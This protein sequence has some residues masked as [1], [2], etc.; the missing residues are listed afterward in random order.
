MS[1]EERELIELRRLFDLAGDVGEVARR[2]GLTRQAVRMKL[3]AGVRRG[4]YGPIARQRYNPGAAD[5]TRSSSEALTGEPRPEQRLY[6]AY[7]ALGSLPAV[8]R[9]FGFSTGRVR[10]LLV[11]AAAEG[12]IPEEWVSRGRALA[13]SFQRLR[14]SEERRGADREDHGGAPTLPSERADA[15][16]KRRCRRCG[17]RI[18]TPDAEAAEENEQAYSEVIDEPMEAS[19]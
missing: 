17:E 1:D 16:A 4:L 2:T 11:R 18:G 7:C 15:V 9:E 13:L 6:L 3:S 12:H 10:A 19:S 14:G 8:A 5:R